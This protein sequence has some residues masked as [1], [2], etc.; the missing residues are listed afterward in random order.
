MSCHLL[1]SI[2]AQL[3]KVVQQTN[4]TIHIPRQTNST[5]GIDV[6]TQSKGGRSP[7]LLNI[8]AAPH[9]LTPFHLSHPTCSTSPLCVI[10]LKLLASKRPGRRWEKCGSKSNRPSLLNGCLLEVQQGAN[11]LTFELRLIHL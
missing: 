9:M 2:K 11:G 6:F 7:L 8:S 1:K 4:H 5:T 3:R 10:L